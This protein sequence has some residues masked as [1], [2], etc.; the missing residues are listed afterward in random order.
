MLSD[1]EWTFII[2][3]FAIFGGAGCTYFGVYAMDCMSGPFERRRQINLAAARDA[4]HSVR[5][6][7]LQ[8]LFPEKV[9]FLFTENEVV[10]IGVVLDISQSTSSLV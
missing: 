6:K 8:K 7:T 9:G 4:T 2:A 5:M 10:G 1:T 3:G